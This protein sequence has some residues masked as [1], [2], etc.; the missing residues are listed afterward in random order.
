MKKDVIVIFLMIIAVVFGVG[1]RYYMQ[2]GSF[3]AQEP[4]ETSQVVMQ[5]PETP[6]DVSQEQPQEAEVSQEQEQTST[7]NDWG[8]SMDA[9]DVTPDG[10]TLVCSQSGGNPTGELSTGAWYE[11]ERLTDGQWQQVPVYAEVCWEDIA[12]IIPAE[13]STEWQVS[14]AWIYGSLE[15]GDYRIAKEIMDFRQTGDY[16]TCRSYA[17][18]TIE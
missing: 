7:D 3:L 11:I 17:Y 6:V 13:G 8:V 1:L 2:T 12:W 4:P 18:F 15:P 9:K 16:D 5:E 10:M 14:W